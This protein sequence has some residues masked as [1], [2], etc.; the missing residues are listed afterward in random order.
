MSVKENYLTKQNI[1]LKTNKWM[2]DLNIPAKR[3][4][5]FKFSSKKST[6]LVIDMQEF[7]LNRESHSYIPA[8][9]IIVPNINLIIDSYRKKDYPIIFT[10][11][12]L[13]IDEE[14]GVMGKWWGD[15]LRVNNPLSK[16]HS[17]IDFN[18]NDIILQYFISS[19]LVT[20]LLGLYGSQDLKTQTHR[21]DN[22]LI[23]DIIVL[24]HDPFGEDS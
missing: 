24:I 20:F 4:N 16:I 9:P 3:M 2:S 17:S 19:T 12:A 23:L 14:P 15:M 8:A 11:H 18:K 22:T 10:F 13:E 7:F 1:S 5:N 6:L 21:Q